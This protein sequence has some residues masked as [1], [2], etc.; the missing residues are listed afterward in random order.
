[1]LG[2]HRLRDWSSGFGKRRARLA[3][4]ATPE[5]DDQRYALEPIPLAE[6]VLEEEPVVAR[7]PAA[8]R[9]LYREARRP[10]AVLGHVVELEA[11]P[12]HGRRL[13][14][15]LDVGEEAVE[16]R[17]GHARRRAVRELDRLEQ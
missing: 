11:P 6:P 3:A 9:H 15:R 5:V 1:M 2:A 4:L 12:P 14:G 7:H 8:V 17:G 13:A 16:L 10:R